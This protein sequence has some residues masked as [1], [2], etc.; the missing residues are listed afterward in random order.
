MPE[1]LVLADPIARQIYAAPAVF[2]CTLTRDGLHRAWVHVIGELD[3]TTNVRSSRRGTPSRAT[4]PLRR[5]GS[6]WAH[7]HGL[8]RRARDRRCRASCPRRRSSTDSRVR[9]VR[10]RTRVRAHRNLGSRAD[11]RPRQRRAGTPSLLQ[12]THERARRMNATATPTDGSKL[13]AVI[14]AP[15]RRARSMRSQARPLSARDRPGSSGRPASRSRI[16]RRR[17]FRRAQWPRGAQ[18]ERSTVAG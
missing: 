10:G 5:A 1:E 17:P 7:L 14:S 4:R 11:G 3:I 6:S 12:R 8:L 13:A 9:T 2:E 15:G 18:R 16:R